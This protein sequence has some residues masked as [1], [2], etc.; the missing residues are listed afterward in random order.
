MYVNY[1]RLRYLF[2]KKHINIILEHEYS[3][4]KTSEKLP[5]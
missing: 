3:P 2:Y 1:D 4:L 5:H